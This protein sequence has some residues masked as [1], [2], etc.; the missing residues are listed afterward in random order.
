ME[1]DLSMD[2]VGFFVQAGKEIMRAVI[3]SGCVCIG[4]ELDKTYLEFRDQR[5]I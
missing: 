4:T 5:E 3:Y 1:L 2:F